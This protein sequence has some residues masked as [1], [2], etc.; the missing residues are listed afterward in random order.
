MRR[1]F[2]TLGASVLQP[3]ESLA[4]EVLDIDLAGLDTP[5]ANLPHGLRVVSDIAPPGV[6]QRYAHKARRRMHAAGEDTLAD[7]NFLMR[8]G[9]SA[10][11]TRFYYERELIRDWLMTRIAARRPAR[12]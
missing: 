4:I 1:L 10:S 3:G 9:R 7:I 12:G 11:G 5:S 8:H 2:E 6:R